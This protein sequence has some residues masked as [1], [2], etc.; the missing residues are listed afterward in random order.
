MDEESVLKV[1]AIVKTAI[2]VGMRKSAKAGES[3]DRIIERYEYATFAF[4]D[5]E[6]VIVPTKRNILQNPGNLP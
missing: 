3:I 5:G 4:R 2:I 1:A 6:L